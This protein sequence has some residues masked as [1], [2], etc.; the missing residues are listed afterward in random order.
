MCLANARR[1]LPCAATN[2][3]FAAQDGRSDLVFP[4]RQDALEGNFE[5]FAIRYDIARQVG[6]AAVVVGGV[7]IFRIEQRRQGVVAAAPK[8]WT[9]SSPYFSAVCFLSITLQLAVVALVQTP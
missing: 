3:R 8:M 9:C 1:E 2:T 5:V 4:E 7:R 6:I